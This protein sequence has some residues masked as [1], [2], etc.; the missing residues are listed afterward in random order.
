[1]QRLVEA[2]RGAD[3]FKLFQRRIVAGQDR[4]GIAGRQP[5]QQEHKQRNHAHH[6]DGGEDAAK[7]ISEHFDP[8]QMWQPVIRLAQT[9]FTAGSVS[10]QQIPC[11]WTACVARV[12][13]SET[14]G[15]IHAGI[16]RF[17]SASSG[18]RNYSSVANSPAISRPRSARLSTSICSLSVWA[19]APRTP[20]PSSV[21]I[22]IAPVKLP[23]EP[24]PAL[25]WGRSRPIC[26]AT[27]RAFS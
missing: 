16:P 7:Q 20:N 10:V 4:G 5:Q 8:L 9:W 11:H 21:G 13:R 14:R 15:H 1:M 19:S 12:K 25:P 22:P 27:P 3:N 2:E 17:R 23:S 18:L 6:G 24:P 26:A